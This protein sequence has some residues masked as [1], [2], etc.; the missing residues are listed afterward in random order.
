MKAAFDDLMTWLNIVRK[1]I[2]E[3]KNESTETNQ[4]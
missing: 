2:S 1:E 4:L 3:P